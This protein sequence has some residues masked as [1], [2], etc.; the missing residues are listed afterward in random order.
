MEPLDYKVTIES[1][2]TGKALKLVIGS[3]KLRSVVA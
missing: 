1:E 3:L 2:G